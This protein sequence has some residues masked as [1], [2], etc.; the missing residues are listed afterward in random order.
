M[1]ANGSRR[2]SV[3]LSVHLWGKVK[4]R[5]GHPAT[6]THTLHA[7]HTRCLQHMQ[8]AGKAKIE[9]ES[10]SKSQ[11]MQGVK[12]GKREGKGVGDNDNLKLK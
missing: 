7:T 10:K 3:H 2:Q 4:I 11:S 5:A 9:M 8:A 1:A 6:H 12:G